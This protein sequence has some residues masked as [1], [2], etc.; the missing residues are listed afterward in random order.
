M[1]RRKGRGT[2][3]GA[4]GALGTRKQLDYESS[5][6][7]IRLSGPQITIG[8][9]DSIA[10][11]FVLINRSLHF[12]KHMANWSH[13]RRDYQESQSAL[14]DTASA[15]YTREWSASELKTAHDF[16]KSVDSPGSDKHLSAAAK[17]ESTLC[18][19]LAKISSDNFR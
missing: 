15:N 13:G 5:L 2:I 8:P 16:F 11:L 7:G 19:S 18:A 17:L 6:L 3:G 9:A 10:L 4:L 14:E 12:Y 1:M